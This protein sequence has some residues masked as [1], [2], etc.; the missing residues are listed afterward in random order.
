[1]I[2]GQQ[3]PSPTKILASRVMLKGAFTH[4]GKIWDLQIGSCCKLA[5]TTGKYARKWVWFW[6]SGHGYKIFVHTSCAFEQVE[7][8]YCKSWICSCQSFSFQLI[9]LL[10]HAKVMYSSSIPR[11]SWQRGGSIQPGST[12]D[13][14][15][16]HSD[17]RQNTY[18]CVLSCRGSWLGTRKYS[19]T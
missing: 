10:R 9:F 16:C 7:P 14:A 5:L 1:M 6:Q 11:S 2:F 17:K 8:S 13:I 4:L 19:Y 18:I 12:T 15:T 3:N